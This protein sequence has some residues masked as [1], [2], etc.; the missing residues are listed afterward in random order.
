[1]NGVSWMPTV[2]PNMD[3]QIDSTADD[4]ACENQD[5]R[6]LSIMDMLVVI[7]TRKN[8]IAKA[9]FWATLVATIGVFLLPNRYTATTTI[10]PPQQNQSMAAMLASQLGNLGPLAS[11]AGKDLG[12]KSPNDMYIGL[13]K[14]ETVEDA[15][16]K[17]F[18]LQKVYRDA[19]FS[20]TRRDLEAKSKFVST[21]EGFIAVAVEDKDP[22]RSAD[23][24]N[25]YVQELQILTGRIAVTEAGQRRIFFE[26]RLDDTKKSLNASEQAFKEVEQ[27]TGIIQLDG[28][29]R[30]II[31]AV[32]QLR[33]QIAAKEVQLQAMRS[34]ATEEN[35]DVTLANQELI[36]LRSQLD[37]LQ[38]QQGTVSGDV[39]VPTGLIPEA[40]LL[41]AQRL[42]E[43]KYNEQLF[44]LLSKQYEAAK[45]DEARQGTVIQVLDPAVVPDKKSSPHR[46]GLILM[47]AVL[48]MF[49]SSVWC[50][51][52]DAFVRRPRLQQ[53]LQL[54]IQLTLRRSAAKA[55]R[56]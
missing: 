4:Y 17:R 50:L 19:R 13:L 56:I 27:K 10:L 51:L 7:A 25:A 36:G 22:G 43:L 3:N 32:V 14:S 21:K 11:V 15:L 38:H 18:D 48:A 33:A 37:R 54:L 23:M 20:D 2:V 35:P 26:Q 24:A 45:M 29:A 34:F 12:I 9:I 30:A 40:G 41:Y 46:A 55:E 5:E 47:V 31:E 1:V 42:R 53:R 8:M 44:E 16:I 28:Q 52:A 6:E 39:Q 49:F